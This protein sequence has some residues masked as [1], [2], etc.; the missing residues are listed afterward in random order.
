MVLRQPKKY[1]Y[2]KTVYKYSVGIGVF[3][4]HFSHTVDKPS[5]ENRDK[6]SL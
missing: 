5:A 6:K 3:T 2:S 4:E 1:K